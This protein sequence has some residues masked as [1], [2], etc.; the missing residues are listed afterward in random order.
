MRTTC[1]CAQ[2]MVW[3][4]LAWHYRAKADPKPVVNT[5]YLR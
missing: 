3:G 5:S 4:S 1:S 2:C